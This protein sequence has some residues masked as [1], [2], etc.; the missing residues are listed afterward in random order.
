VRDPGLCLKAGLDE[1]A[2]APITQI[3]SFLEI[4]QGV[5]QGGRA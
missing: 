4:D 1:A 5:V 3:G 2:P